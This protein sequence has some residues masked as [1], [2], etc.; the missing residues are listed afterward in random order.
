MRTACLT[1]DEL[2]CWSSGL[3]T[4]DERVA[5]ERHLDVCPLCSG[6]L[7]DLGRTFGQ[8]SLTES[9]FVL[10][11]ERDEP[12]PEPGRRPVP[13]LAKLQLSQAAVLT[14][15]FPLLTRTAS[16][17]VSWPWLAVWFGGLITWSLVNSVGCVRG[18]RWAEPSAKW[19][20]I[21]A[22]VSVVT[23]AHAVYTWRLL[24]ERRR[25]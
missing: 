10:M 6:L 2:A 14:L 22:L 1:D 8:P 20:A 13:P 9:D 4:P 24:S 5:A 25:R 12:R 18:R 17:A 23:A 16:F 19:A 21:F 3:L 11:S 15:A 7:A